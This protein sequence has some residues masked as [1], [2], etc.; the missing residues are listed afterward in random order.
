[1]GDIPVSKVP[2]SIVGVHRY[3]VTEELFRKTLEYQ[4]GDDLAGAEMKAAERHVREHFEN[5]YVLEVLVD[6]QI[7]DLNWSEL[8]QEIP[9]QSRENWQVPY[10]EQALD[11]TGRRWTFFF[12]F[13]DLRKPLLTSFGPIT[14]PEPTELPPHLAFMKY[15]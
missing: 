8:T 15:V 13:L 3:P 7:E 6:E 11:D 10:D 2:I 14:L 4:W 1:M 5:L 12:H 9:D